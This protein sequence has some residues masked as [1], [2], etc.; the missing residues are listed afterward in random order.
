MFD[1]NKPFTIEDF[2]KLDEQIKEIL[3]NPIPRAIKVDAKMMYQLEKLP[4]T[5]KPDNG[6]SFSGIQVILDESVDGWEFVFDED[7]E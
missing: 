6:Y 3:S 5:T 2:R 1:I 7:K 4:S